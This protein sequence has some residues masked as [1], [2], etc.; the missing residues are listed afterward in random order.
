MGRD[1]CQRGHGGARQRR[2]K[3]AFG[4]LGPELLGSGMGQMAETARLSVPGPWRGKRLG[5]RLM[6]VRRSQPCHRGGY[7]TGR[8]E[9]RRG[10]AGSTSS[11]RAAANRNGARQIQGGE[12]RRRTEHDVRIPPLGAITASDAV[13]QDDPSGVHQ[14]TH[15]RWGGPRTSPTHCDSRGRARSRSG[16]PAGSCPAA[17]RGDLAD[18]RA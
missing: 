9:G 5:A 11:A 14:A 6:R 18:H 12:H 10:R 16:A 4:R 17:R 13:P 2:S 7:D 3:R 1:T 15:A 8:F